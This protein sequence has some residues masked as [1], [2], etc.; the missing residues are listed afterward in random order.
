MFCR[1]PRRRTNQH[2]ALPRNLREHW[3]RA[4]IQCVREDNVDIST[5]SVTSDVKGTEDGTPVARCPVA[6][7]MHPMGRR[8]VIRRHKVPLNVNR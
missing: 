3:Q 8:D 4:D 7:L 2:R 5:L 6:R 1:L